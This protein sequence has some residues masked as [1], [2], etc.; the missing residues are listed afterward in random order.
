MLFTYSQKYE[1]LEYRLLESS[2]FPS[3]PLPSLHFSKVNVV[4]LFGK[5][6]MGEPSHAGEKRLDRRTAMENIRH[7]IVICQKHLL[8]YA[9]KGFLKIIIV[10]VDKL[11][12]YTSGDFYTAEFDSNAHL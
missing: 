6:F 8:L 9:A 4:V 3:F 11:R 5:T 1:L 2:S 10:K 7:Y 12:F